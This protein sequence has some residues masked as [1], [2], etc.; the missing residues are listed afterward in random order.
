M[1]ITTLLAGLV[2]GATGGLAGALF[3]VG[4]GIVMVP[5]YMKLL[6]MPF[7]HAVGTSLAVIIVTS[8]VATTKNARMGLIDFRIAG[9]AAVGAIVAAIYGSELMYK[10][11]DATLT[12]AFGIFLILIGLKLALEK[13]TPAPLPT[14]QSETRN[15]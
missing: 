10:L 1:S 6:H 13:A 9:I 3:G 4:G 14:N 15:S 5:A 11:K 8:V 2:I 12:R 7:K